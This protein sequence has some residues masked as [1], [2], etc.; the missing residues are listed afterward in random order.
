VV[1]P[2]CKHRAFVTANAPYPARNLRALNVQLA[3]VPE[4]T[5]MKRVTILDSNVKLRDILRV[6]GGD[7]VRS[8]WRVRGVECLGGAAADTLHRASD[9]QEILN[10]AVFVGLA[11]R[12]DQTVEGEFE[13]RFAGEQTPWVTIEAIDGSMFD[14]ETDNDRLL[15]SLAAAFNR[16]QEVPE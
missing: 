2:V 15:T 3:C 8:E 9:A 6:L 10:G 13:A 12:L 16:V 5:A 11:E 14:V 4:W 1:S 7:A